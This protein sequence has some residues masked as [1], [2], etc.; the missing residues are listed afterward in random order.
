M[1]LEKLGVVF[2]SVVSVRRK[3]AGE[4]AIGAGAAG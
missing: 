4:C 1:T 3:T 2:G